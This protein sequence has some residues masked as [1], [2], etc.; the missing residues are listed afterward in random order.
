MSFL[1]A[2]LLETGPRSVQRKEPGSLLAGV[3]ADN[4]PGSQ[5]GARLSGRKPLLSSL[6]P[7]E[8]AVSFLTAFLLEAGSRSVQFKEPRSNYLRG[9]LMAA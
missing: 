1:T 4:P 3:L 7:K 6:F 2:F 9:F 8:K 5:T